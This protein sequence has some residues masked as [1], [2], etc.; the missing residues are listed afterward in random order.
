MRTSNRTNILAFN[1]W[2]L[3]LPFLVLLLLCELG[4]TKYSCAQTLSFSTKSDSSRFVFDTV[5]VNMLGKKFEINRNVTEYQTDYGKTGNTSVRNI[6]KEELS[7]KTQ[8]YFMRNRDLGQLFIP[9]KDTWLKSIVLRTGPARS[10]VL[11]NT[12][13]AKVFV[14]FFE[15]SGTP[16]IN[17]NG[18]PKGTPS[19]HGFNTNHRTDD[20]IEG[21]EYKIMDTIYVGTFP[22]DIPNTRDSTG[23]TIGTEGNLVYLRWSFNNSIFFEANKRYGFMVGLLESG[24]GFGFTL[25]NANRAAWGNVPSLDDANTPYK[26]GWAFRREG[27]GTLPPTMFP[28]EEPPNSDSLIQALKAESFF[29]AGD[30]R[31]LLSPTSDGFPDVDTYRAYEFYLEEENNYVETEG[32]TLNPDSLRLSVGDEFSLQPQFIPQNATNQKVDWFTT[33]DSVV[34]IDS[35]GKLKAHSPGMAAITVFANDSYFYATS[36]VFV[37]ELTSSGFFETTE[38]P[39]ILLFPNPVKGEKF[40]IHSSDEKIKHVYLYSVNGQLMQNFRCN[41]KDV[42]IVLQSKMSMYVVKVVTE[43][44][45]YTQLLMIKQ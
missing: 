10:A 5:T 6:S 44:E 27:D 8:G 24:E 16:V 43:K 20:Y 40:K 31:F 45:N 22:E 33:D 14:Q 28:G 7:W 30:E 25:A 38:S 21:I 19:T 17:D 34:S 36:I 15:I 1:R 13:G 2:F 42:E 18:T 9:K 35:T 37:N 32:I 41:S 11:Y 26:G 23:A 39:A 29:R 12:P 3:Y 4:F